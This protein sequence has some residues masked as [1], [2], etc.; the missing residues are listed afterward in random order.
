MTDFAPFT[1]TEAP[2]PEPTPVPKV[3]PKRYAGPI[4]LVL[5]LLAALGAIIA[6]LVQGNS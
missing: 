3:K 5:G 6:A 1:P 4:G 2:E